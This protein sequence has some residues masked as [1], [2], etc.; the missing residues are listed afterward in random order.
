MTQTRKMVKYITKDKL[1]HC[2]SVFSWYYLSSMKSKSQHTR[3]L[4]LRCFC[5]L[6]CQNCSEILPCFLLNLR[7]TQK[8]PV[9][10]FPGT[11]LLRQPTAVKTSF[12]ATLSS[13]KDNRIFAALEVF[14]HFSFNT[15]CHSLCDSVFS[16][17]PLI[18][19]RSTSGIPSTATW[20]DMTCVVVGSH[21]SAERRRSSVV[22]S[23][24][25]LKVFPGDLLVSDSAL[26][27]LP[28][29][30]LLLNAGQT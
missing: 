11:S 5:G 10:K 19:A 1:F 17:L 30:A 2:Y 9:F 4:G 8:F 22:V 23:L 15:L 18:S 26:D 14:S 13:W 25:G 16:S 7:R 24:P 28:H 3:H 20:G 21:R 12:L 29:A 27:Y 6:Q